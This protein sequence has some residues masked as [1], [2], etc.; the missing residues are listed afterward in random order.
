MSDRLIIHYKHEKRFRSFK[1]DMHLIYEEVFQ[2]TS[3][4]AVEIV[5]GSRNRRDDKKELIHK[6]PI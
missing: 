3:V 1:R 6:R 4:M 5:V 2:N